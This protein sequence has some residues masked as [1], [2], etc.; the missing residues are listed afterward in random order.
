M[1]LLY[2]LSLCCGCWFSELGLQKASLFSET[3]RF[4]CIF[5]RAPASRSPASGSSIAVEREAGLHPPSCSGRAL[6]GPLRLWLP[7]PGPALALGLSP[8]TWRRRLETRHRELK[9]GDLGDHQRDQRCRRKGAGRREQRHLVLD[10]TPQPRRRARLCFPPTPHPIPGHPT[11]PPTPAP[12][13]C[14]GPSP[15]LPGGLGAGDRAL[16]FL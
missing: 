2:P 8:D 10:P 16:L 9:P 6:S 1:S 12:L 15:P 5:A 7:E 11:A 3:W 4:S 14:P 13:R